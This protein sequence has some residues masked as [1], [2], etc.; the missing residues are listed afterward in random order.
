MKFCSKAKLGSFLVLALVPI[1]SALAG[2]LFA[3]ATPA[4]SVSSTSAAGS[5]LEAESSR[6]RHEHAKSR[7]KERT[8]PDA[9]ALQSLALGGQ[10]EFTRLPDSVE[11]AALQLRIDRLNAL[12]DMTTRRLHRRMAAVTERMIERGEL[13]PSVASED[14]ARDGLIGRRL[15]VVAGVPYAKTFYPG[16]DEEIDALQR[17]RGTL[18]RL[19]HDALRTAFE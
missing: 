11:L 8:Y 6:A 17:R 10:L 1:G 7:P 16:D 19:F 3:G 12:A 4:G 2:V 14:Q 5:R 13:Q 15:I 18:T 9:A